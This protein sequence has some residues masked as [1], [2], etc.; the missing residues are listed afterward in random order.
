MYLK[1]KKI[2]KSTFVLLRY[3]IS[4]EM[5]RSVSTAKEKRNP[6]CLQYS[7]AHVCYSFVKSL[8]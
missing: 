1:I 5:R 4:R 6:S 7:C 2:A 3:I 8:H